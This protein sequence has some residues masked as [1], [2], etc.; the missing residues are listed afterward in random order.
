MKKLVI[1][2][3]NK[4]KV[5][6]FRSLFAKYPISI[7]TLLDFPEIGEIEETGTTFAENA[8]IKAETVS[9][10]LNIPVLADDSGLMVD[11]LDGAP[12]IYS[13]RYA[14][15]GHDDEKNNEKLLANLKGVPKEKRTAKFHCTLAIAIPAEPT[16]FYDGEVAGYITEE[17]SGKSGFGYDPLFY[18]PNYQAT[19]AELDPAEKNKISHRASA[20]ANL[21]KDLEKVIKKMN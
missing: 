13:A 8:A 9:K 7:Q 6:E 17:K 10:R 14:G 12:G 4:G 2:T 18:L 1:A 16:Y 21:S 3:A 11:Y 15:S 19:M 5:E 20:L